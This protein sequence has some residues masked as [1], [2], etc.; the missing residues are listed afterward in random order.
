MGRLFFL[1]TILGVSLAQGVLY[2]VDP[3]A[4]TYSVWRAVGS[5]IESALADASIFLET[6]SSVDV[7]RL[8]IRVTC[9]DGYIDLALYEPSSLPLTG[10]VLSEAKGVY[11]RQGGVPPIAIFPVG[12]IFWM[13]YN[14][15]TNE[16]L[17]RHSAA[18]REYIANQ[19]GS[20]VRY[21]S[22][23]QDKNRAAM[24]WLDPY[25]QRPLM[26][27]LHYLT[28]AGQIVRLGVLDTKA[29]GFKLNPQNPIHLEFLRWVGLR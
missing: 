17:E 16:M 13:A 12:Y 14:A 19:M 5:N 23:I 7:S 24:V 9:K 6:R 15:A 1:V 27:E 29:G 18:T 26:Y 4:K 25:H 28:P 8:E 20:K 22:A 11:A 3:C 2:R 10:R 21:Y